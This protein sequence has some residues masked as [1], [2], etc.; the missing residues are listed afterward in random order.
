MRVTLMVLIVS[1]TAAMSG[2]GQK[3]DENSLG[4]SKVV[5]YWQ[6][7]NTRCADSQRIGTGTL[8]IQNDGMVY[9][10]VNKKGVFGYIGDVNQMGQFMPTDSYYNKLSKAYIDNPTGIPAGVLVSF[11]YDDNSMQG[12]TLTVEISAS[13]AAGG[14]ISGQPQVVPVASEKYFKTSEDSADDMTIMDGCDSF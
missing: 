13:Y 1:L 11:A 14:P 12:Q 7:Q 3:K 9:E 5:G 4:G 6:S 10:R 2:C 8:R